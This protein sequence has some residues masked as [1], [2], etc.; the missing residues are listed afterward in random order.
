MRLNTSAT[1]A[2]IRRAEVQLRDSDLFLLVLAL[3]AGGAAG[4]SV[5]VIDLLLAGLRWFAFAIPRGAHLSDIGLSPARVL[6]MP[7]LGGLLVGLASALLR[8][9]RQREVVDAIEANALFGGRMSVGDSLGLVLLTLLSGGFGASVGLEAAYTQLGAALASRLGRSVGLRR[10]DVRTLVGCG[11]AGAIAAAFNAPLTGAFYA[12]ELIIGVYTLQT[13]APVGMA[14]FCFF[15]AEDGIRE[16]KVT[17]VQTC[18][19]PI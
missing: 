4:L 13:L 10:D 6:L 3:G 19:L 1:T 11:A 15:Q 14:V 16:Y 18:A 17:G 7:V 8:S 5:I 12:F 9:W 2:G